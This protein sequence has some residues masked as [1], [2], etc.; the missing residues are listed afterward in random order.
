MCWGKARGQ[1]QGADGGGGGEA[2]IEMQK[3]LP[4]REPR[5]KAKSVKMCKRVP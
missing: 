5:A 4:F 3:V 2:K 1:R